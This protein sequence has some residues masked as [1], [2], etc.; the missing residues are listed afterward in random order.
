MAPID[1]V[2]S[3]AVH[4][5]FA[6]AWTGAVLFF[7]W[8]VLPLARDGTVAPEV[9]G[10]T[11]GKLTTLTRA[12][13]V[14]LFVTGGHQAGR[15]YT[16]ESLTGSQLG[17]LVVTMLVLWLALA[18]LVEIGASKIRSGVDEEKVRTPAHDAHTIFRAASVVAV[19]LLL[20]AGV[21]AV[22][23]F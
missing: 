11:T 19:L 14:V 5:L 3:Y 15:L 9:L 22:G 18:A 21:L 20:D 10:R 7:A 23:G 16:V 17:H 2:V 8:A 6:A 4:M 13:A 12:S 1:L